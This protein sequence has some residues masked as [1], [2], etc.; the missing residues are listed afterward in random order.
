MDRSFMHRGTLPEAL[1][2]NGDLVALSRVA[3]PVLFLLVPL[4]SGDLPR[5]RRSSL[6]S[7]DR[8]RGDLAIENLEIA[9]N[10]VEVFLQNVDLIGSKTLKPD[11]L[12]PLC[13]RD[14]PFDQG[15]SRL[16]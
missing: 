8:L 3:L 12:M 10:S 13:E 9:I 11:L 6:C 5:C 4:Q 14:E 2:P 16:G 7:R 15:A 1:D